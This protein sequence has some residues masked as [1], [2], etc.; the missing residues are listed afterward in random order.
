MGVM[1][2]GPVYVGWLDTQRQKD[3][4]EQ[5]FGGHHLRVK[6]L[7]GDFCTFRLRT[8]RHED[9]FAWMIVV[10]SVVTWILAWKIGDCVGGVRGRKCGIVRRRPRRRDVCS[11]LRRDVNVGAVA[12]GLER[13]ATTCVSAW[14][15]SV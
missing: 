13:T 8:F 2:K 11:S 6:S 10:I 12:V 3:V 9:G 14:D 4:L 15:S 1:G 7:G 5:L